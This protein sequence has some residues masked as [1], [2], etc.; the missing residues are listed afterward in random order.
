M[1]T[2]ADGDADADADAEG[3]NVAD[4][5]DDVEGDHEADADTVLNRSP[6]RRNAC[7]SDADTRA[8]A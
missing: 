2:D 8:T 7:A 3:E 5:H 4:P 1:P 6:S